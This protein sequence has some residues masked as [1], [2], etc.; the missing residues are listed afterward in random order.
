MNRYLL[1]LLL[2]LFFCSF[3]LPLRWDSKDD[4]TLAAVLAG[5]SGPCCSGCPN[6][7]AGRTSKFEFTFLVLVLMYLQ[8]VPVS[9]CS[10]KIK[11]ESMLTN[12]LGRK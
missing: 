10:L 4:R 12:H 7:P 1:W 9:S 6:V 3:L 2:V 5:S 11:G 8:F